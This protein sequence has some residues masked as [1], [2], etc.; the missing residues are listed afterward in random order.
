MFKIF[1]RN[2]ALGVIIGVILF[3]TAKRI[4]VSN[5]ISCVFTIYFVQRPFH[6]I[7]D[8]FPVSPPERRA[9]LTKANYMYPNS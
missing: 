9:N 5:Q 8:I 3:C 7:A 6:V 4:L 2:F 1:L